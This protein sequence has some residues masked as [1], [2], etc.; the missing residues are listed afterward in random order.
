MSKKM[1]HTALAAAIAL[2]LSSNFAFAMPSGA[3]VATGA[4]SVSGLTADGT[5]ASGGTLKALKNAII[6]WNSFDIAKGESLTLDTSSAFMLNRVTGSMPTTI[7]GILKQVGSNS[8]IVINPYGF[9][10]SGTS[11]IDA[12]NL[13]VSTLALSDNDFNSM[14]GGKQV[15]FTS[16]NVNNGMTTSGDISFDAGAKVKIGRAHV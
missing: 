5:I 9:T 16:Q 6:N 7:D 11:S 2:A 12:N 13:I 10:F 14:A 4:D 3:T 15:T 1:K 8:A